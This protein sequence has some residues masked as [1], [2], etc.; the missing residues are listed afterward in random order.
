[1]ALPSTGSISMSQI[2]TELGRS[3]TA[4]ISLDSAE[5]GSYAS[6]NQCANSVPSSTNPAAMSEWRGYAQNAN[7][8]QIY[9]TQNQDNG[10]SNI[11]LYIYDRNG[12][13]VLSDYWIWDNFF[14]SNLASYLGI[15]IGGGYTVQMY[16]YNWSGST[17]TTTG[18]YAYFYNSTTSTYLNSG[19]GC[20]NGENGPW[21]VVVQASNNYS[22]YAYGFYNPNGNPF[23][24]CCFC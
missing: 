21:N 13:A 24:C 1:M 8:P 22:M 19:C 11:R 12:N 4:Q 20:G 18:I 5:N 7:C 15:T 9:V 6:I 14:T 3:S 10:D 2:N 23:G 17:W 16:T